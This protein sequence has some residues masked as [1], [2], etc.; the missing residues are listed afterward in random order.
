MG[1]SHHQTENLASAYMGEGLRHGTNF[2]P[3][4]IMLLEIDKNLI[5]SI[6]RWRFSPLQLSFWKLQLF[7]WN[8]NSCFFLYKRKCVALGLNSY[9][10][11]FY[12]CFWLRIM[13]IMVPGH[14]SGNLS[15]PYCQCW[16]TDK[17]PARRLTNNKQYQ[18]PFSKLNNF[19]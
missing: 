4:H 1:G 18:I 13:G 6:K 11:Y 8:P 7:H 14:I 17:W 3:S 15:K 5:E 9:S 19:S 12:M 10:E 2:T 16:G